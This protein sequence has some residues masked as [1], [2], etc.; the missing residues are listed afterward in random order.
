MEPGTPT[1]I[2]IIAIFFF[3][4]F[5]NIIVYMVTKRRMPIGGWIAIASGS[6]VVFC[7]VAFALIATVASGLD[8]LQLLPISVIL[9]IICTFLFWIG[10]RMLK[11]PINDKTTK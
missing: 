7:F 4:N 11:A 3:I 5:I 10:S 2:L 8:P 9:L 6:L 1:A